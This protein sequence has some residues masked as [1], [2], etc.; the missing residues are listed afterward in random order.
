MRVVHVGVLAC[1]LERSSEADERESNRAT[2]EKKKAWALP[3]V[4]ITSRRWFHS[5]CPTR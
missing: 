2:P 5:A 4:V 1:A 3:A